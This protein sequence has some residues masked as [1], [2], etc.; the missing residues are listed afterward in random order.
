MPDT[1]TSLNYACDWRMG[2]NLSPKL[3][4]AVGYLMF[5][6]GCGGLTLQPDIRVPNPFSSSGQTVVRGESVQ[7]VGLIEQLSYEGA[8]DDP[9]RIVA[10]VSKGAASNLRAKLASP[11]TTTKLKLSFYLINY[12]D[13]R[14]CWYESVLIRDTG[15]KVDA[16]VDSL[17]GVLQ[18]FV[19]TEG[20]AIADHLD[21]RVF[22][23]EFQVAPAEGKVA[24]VEFA[25]G[26]I[27]RVVKRWGA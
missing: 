3:K 17:D 27:T 23:V 18:L 12:D 19:S 16:V 21:V 24:N 15:R 10:Y 26:P 4:G 8:A 5:W 13:E 1:P 9:I 20:A 25:T 7:C 22:R 11:L 6:S 14:K 2:F